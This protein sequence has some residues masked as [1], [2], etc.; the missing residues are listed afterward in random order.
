MNDKQA[1]LRQL[2]KM[3][4]L[5]SDTELQPAI[6]EMGQTV[7]R[8]TARATLD[9][10]RTAL[11]AGEVREISQ[12]GVASAVLSRLAAEA[13]P[14][15]HAVI[16][17]TGVPLHTNLGRA[18]IG[19]RVAKAAMEIACGYSTLEY[20]CE[21]GGRGSRHDHAKELLTRLCGTEDA[22][23]V[24]NNAA[25]VMLALGAMAQNKEV[26][27]SRGELVE[28]G[29]AFRVPE[30]MEL[31]GSTLKEVGTTNKT[32]FADY[33]HAITPETGALL[34]VHTSNFRIV[35][36]TEETPLA[37]LAKLGKAHHI[38]VIYDLGGGALVDLEKYGIHEEPNV[39]AVLQSG[40]DILT[41]SGDKLL[42]GPQAGIIVGKKE[43]IDR[44]KAHPLARAVR[45]D[46]VTLAMLCETLRCY[47][48]EQVALREIP[49][50]R[51]LA[52][53]PEGMAERAKPFAE[54]LQQ[55]GIECSLVPEFDQVGGGSV[56][57]QLL[58]STVL[59]IDDRRYSAAAL[60][61]KLRHRALPIIV[62]V[63]R[64]AVLFGLRTLGT[65]ELTAIVTA[66]TEIFSEKESSHE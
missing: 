36:F 35:G 20:S 46:K 10:I 45:V 5:L 58:P 21:R 30:I 37:D 14:S 33:E 12:A 56:P 16:N 51:M 29:G 18:V 28:I 52:D 60:E 34:K 50:M 31:S 61:E 4:E 2:P 54:Q 9:A 55:A 38:P 49:V 27:V 22:M 59:R 3:D 66:L 41:F 6:A 44:M 39:P 8:E 40:V 7:V 17:A 32:H 64:D 65:A 13:R 11:L 24:N 62:R 47:L 26:V 1:L 57:T 53:T 42:G 63:T 43:Y 25:A 19:E 23:V 15:L 48:D